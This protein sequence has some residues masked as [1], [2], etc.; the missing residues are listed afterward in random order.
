MA[1]T[2]YDPIELEAAPVAAP[3]RRHVLLVGALLASAAGAALIG[4]LLAGYFSARDLA[5]ADNVPWVP[6]GTVLPNV[7]LFVVYIGLTLSGFTAVWAL[8]AIKLDDRRQAYLAFA[9]TIGLGLLFIN[10][11]SFCWS[12]LALVAGS[13]PYATHVYAVTVVHLLLMVAAIV[14]WIV[15]GFRVLGG[16][17]SPSSTEPILAAIVVWHFVVAS[18]LVIWWCLWF[19]E[20]GPG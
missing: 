19:L 3:G 11:I 20:G 16:Q 8:A 1:V 14:L 18:G 13:T 6:D 10:G 4:A 2:A 17:L 9:S 5:R 7:A 15:V 12:R